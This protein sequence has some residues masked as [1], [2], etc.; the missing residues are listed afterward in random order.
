MTVTI[1]F[2]DLK[3]AT[4]EARNCGN[5]RT[6]RTDGGDC[7]CGGGG[8]GEGGCGEGAGG[9]DD[10]LFGGGGCGGVGELV[11]GENL[12]A[13]AVRLLACD[14]RVLPIVLGSDSRPL[15]V[16]TSKRFV[17][18][19]I[20]SALIKRDKGCVICK[21]P[22]WQ[23]HAH[24][25][26]HWADGGPTSLDNLVLACSPH[27]TA[28][29]DGQWIVTITHGTV[30]VTRPSWADPV[31]RTLADLTNLK[32]T[33]SAPWPPPTSTSNS[34]VNM[35]VNVDPIHEQPTRPP[36]AASLTRAPTT[37][38]AGNELR[39]WLTPQAT[40]QL[41]PWGDTPSADP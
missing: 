28:I 40:A 31:A 34:N 13:S 9:G 4:A 36:A 38:I 30:E 41:N 11:F 21:A 6:D 14:A 15:D 25:R 12:S 24:H 1:D 22:P 10:G 18:D 16:G 32:D 19:A 20:R 26:V 3:A 37:T 29:H 2:D 39:S 23:C 27:H 35:N 33:T 17:T 8:C 5:S 7:G